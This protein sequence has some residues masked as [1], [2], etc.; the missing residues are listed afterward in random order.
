MYRDIQLDSK[1][2]IRG[3]SQLLDRA[4]NPSLQ[5]G[6]DIRAHQIQLAMERA[7]LKQMFGSRGDRLVSLLAEAS[8]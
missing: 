1:Q 2:A 7:N 3:R 5:K 8:C 4:A 6:R